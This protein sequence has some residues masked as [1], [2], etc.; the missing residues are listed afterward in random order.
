[1]SWIRPSRINGRVAAPPSKSAMIRATAAAALAEGASEI[2]RPSFC[3]DALAGLGIVSALGAEVAREDG[4]VT[5]RGP[6]SPR[7]GIL[8][9]GESGLCLRLFA[10]IA[11]LGKGRITL[12]ARGSLEARPVGPIEAPLAGLGASVATRSGF[13]PLSVEGPMRGGSVAVDGSVTSQFLTGLL[14]AL[15]VCPDDSRL[16]VS[17][18]KSRP[19]VEMTVSILERFSVFTNWDRDRDIFEI[20]GRRRLSPCRYEVE[21]DW[22]GAA[23]LLVAAALT[24][25]VTVDHLSVDSRQADVRVLSAL[26]DAGADVSIS[27]DSVTAGAGALEAFEFDAVDCPDLF[28]PL[29]VLAGFCRGRSVIHGVDRLR[30][31]ESDRAAALVEE[32]SRLGG[33]LGISGNS[34]WIEGGGLE[35]GVLDSRGDHRLA[36]AGA[37]AGLRAAR[38]V[39]ILGPEA[40][41]K[42]YPGFFADLAALGGDI[43]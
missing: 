26:V 37:V 18:L 1:M 4:L 12:A 35:G 27:G 23:F 13:P 7:D 3:D 41:D 20:E 5:I 40:V 29:T 42:S 24:G 28:P 33:S 34:L 36:M 21:G 10:P 2:V 15:P 11:A 43:S 25:R 14:T 30:H 32:L 9:C 22:S 6:I 17:D 16:A 39:R 8:D 38:G 31:K 19:Y